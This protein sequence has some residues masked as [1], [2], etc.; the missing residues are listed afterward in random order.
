MVL[1][2]LPLFSRRPIVGCS[3]VHTTVYW[4]ATPNCEALGTIFSLDR[5]HDNPDRDGERTVCSFRLDSHM[6]ARA[7][8]SCRRLPFGLCMIRV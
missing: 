2:L 1:T 8:L 3:L 7:A 5:R 4:Q 6:S